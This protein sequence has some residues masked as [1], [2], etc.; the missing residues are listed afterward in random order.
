MTML[1]GAQCGRERSPAPTKKNDVGISTAHPYFMLYMLSVDPKEVP[2]DTPYANTTKKSGYARRMN[3]ALFSVDSK[4]IILLDSQALFQAIIT[5]KDRN[6]GEMKAMKRSAALVLLFAL[7]FVN[8]SLLALGKK[9]P[10]PS[11]LPAETVLQSIGM[12]LVWHADIKAAAHDPVHD[13]Y[14]LDN[15][16]AIETESCKLYV[17]DLKTGVMVW[18]KQLPFPVEY[19]PAINDKLVF[20]ASGER[21]FA[22]SRDMGRTKWHRKINFPI[23]AAPVATN[24]IVA[25]PGRYLLHAFNTADGSIAWDFRARARIDCNPVADKEHFYFGDGSG[26][27]YC[28]IASIGRRAWEKQTR[29]SV[30]A[31]FWV[32]PERVYAGSMDFKVYACDTKTGKPLWDMSIGS[33]VRQRP[34]LVG[35]DLYAVS[36]EKNMHVLNATDGCEKRIIKGAHR[37]LAVGK[38]NVY[39]LRG[40]NEILAVDRQSGEIKWS[41]KDDRHCFFP[42]NPSPQSGLLLLINRKGQIAALREK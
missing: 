35:C 34:V 1:D 33:P 18:Q 12:E 19:A 17:V 4:G 10:P 38:A 30:V 14:I 11:H 25:V 21:L 5:T 15:L 9:A 27:I 31:P 20:V 29:D 8:P 24:D 22:L 41:T 26:W 32:S 39:L 2:G 28:L 3:S 37:V 16:L 7:S 23:T 13:V 36:Y 40:K 6:G 42:S